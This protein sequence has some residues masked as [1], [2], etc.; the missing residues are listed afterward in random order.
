MLTS[1]LFEMCE[2]GWCAHWLLLKMLHKTCEVI[3][4][5]Y[6]T[7]ILRKLLINTEILNTP[8][9]PDPK[10]LSRELL[11][12]RLDWRYYQHDELILIIH[13]YFTFLYMWTL[14]ERSAEAADEWRERTCGASPHHHRKLSLGQAVTQCGSVSV[15]DSFLLFVSAVRG[16]TT[17]RAPSAAPTSGEGNNTQTHSKMSL[18]NL[19][20]AFIQKHS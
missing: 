4:V 1:V 2:S 19:S 15:S 8:I 20:L 9:I 14:F 3:S 12:L 5:F 10:L 6:F 18:I 13:I 7:S 16:R 17:Q 11:F